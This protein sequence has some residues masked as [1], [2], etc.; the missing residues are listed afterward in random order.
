VPWLGRR[1]LRRS[2]AHGAGCLSSRR[3]RPAAPV[4]VLASTG[5][6]GGRTL[7]AG[8][9]SSENHV[10]DEAVF[11]WWDYHLF[12]AVSALYGVAVAM[13]YPHDNCVLDEGNDDRV[14]ALCCSLGARHFSRKGLSEYQTSSGPF[15]AKTK[16]GNYNAWLAEIGFA[17]YD[18][19]VGFDPDHIPAPRFL[20]RVLGYFDDPKVGF[21]Q[22]AQLYYNQ[23]ASFVA[24]GAA[25]ETYAYYSSIQMTAY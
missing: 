24:K 9:P 23:G 2:G 14:K 16:H 3:C 17:N 12:A 7:M 15:Q 11:A 18:I 21:V 4:G 5:P 1:D 25:E 8:R 6:R 19:V 20:S 22:A 10:V 13:D